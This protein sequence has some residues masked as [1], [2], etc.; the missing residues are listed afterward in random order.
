LHK[1]ITKLGGTPTKEKAGL[2]ILTS[3]ESISNMKNTM[4]SAESE[5]NESEQDTIIENAEITAY[6]ICLY[7]GQ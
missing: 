2:P 7:N 5:L 6:I 1:I 3:P 4:T